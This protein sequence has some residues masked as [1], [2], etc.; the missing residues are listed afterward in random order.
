MVVHCFGYVN[1]SSPIFSL[2][3]FPNLDR[4]DASLVEFLLEVIV[5]SQIHK[6]FP[7]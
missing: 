7:L 2:R 1:V 6:D 4:D 5:C 3:I